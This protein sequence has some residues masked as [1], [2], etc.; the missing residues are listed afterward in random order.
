M[1]FKKYFTLLILILIFS[2]LNYSQKK[3]TRTLFQSA[4]INALLNG[5]MNDNFTVGEITKHGSFGLG[6]FNGVDGEMIVLDGKVYRVDSKGNV[7]LPG[8]LVRTPF[9]AVTYFHRDTVLIIHD[10]LSMKQLL[11]YMIRI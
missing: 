10:S 4:P 11:E 9:A 1:L 5:V 7:T 8:K 6:T 3:N 2:S